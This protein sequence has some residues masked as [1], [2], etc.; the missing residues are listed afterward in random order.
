MIPVQHPTITH[1]GYDPETKTLYIHS[2]HGN[3][4]YE[5][6]PRE[7]FVAGLADPRK[8]AHGAHPKAAR[9]VT[10]QRIEEEQGS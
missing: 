2:T 1:A 10:G 3:W 5:K 4:Q 8:F 7:R 9:K 6:V